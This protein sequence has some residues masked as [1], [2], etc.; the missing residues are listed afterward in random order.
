MNRLGEVHR[1]FREIQVDAY[2]MVPSLVQVSLV[3]GFF[4]N[5]STEPAS[6]IFRHVGDRYVGQK[7]N[8]WAQT[9]NLSRPSRSLQ[10]GKFRASRS[11]L[12]ESSS[13]EVLEKGN[14][15]R[16]SG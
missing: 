2:C 8:P 16:E 5:I 10:S 13:E 3:H 4:D 14:E 6:A 11:N 15:T 7:A 1:L 9:Y 12:S